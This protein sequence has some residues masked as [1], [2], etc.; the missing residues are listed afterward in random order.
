MTW[1][2]RPKSVR[3]GRG[4]RDGWERRAWGKLDGRGKAGDWRWCLEEDIVVANGGLC[5][6]TSTYQDRRTGKMG[7]GKPARQLLA[8]CIGIE[9][10]SGIGV[11]WIVRR[12]RG[13]SQRARVTRVWRGR[14]WAGLRPLLGERR[15]MDH[16]AIHEPN[17]SEDGRGRMESWFYPKRGN[18]ALC[19]KRIDRRHVTA[20]RIS[21][22]GTLGM[23]EE[24]EATDRH[25]QVR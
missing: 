4:H 25:A 20:L 2:L 14:M 18:S 11:L 24:V 19:S 6:R 23:A 16:R 1:K 3:F 17:C 22:L 21:A 12:I 15:P 5:P 10:R 9:R 8:D 13:C 7:L